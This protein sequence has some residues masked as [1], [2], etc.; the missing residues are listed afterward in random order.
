MIEKSKSSFL[1][2]L[3]QLQECAAIPHRHKKTLS[4]ADDGQKDLDPLGIEPRTFC[5][6]KANYSNV[7]Q[8]LMQILEFDIDIRFSDAAYSYH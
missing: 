8:T 3:G 1:I 5:A 7:K 6:L 4:F 2:R